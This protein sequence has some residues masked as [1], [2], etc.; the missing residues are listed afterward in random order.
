MEKFNHETATVAD[1]I[2]VMDFANGV[3]EAL[4]PNRDS[5]T[6]N[7]KDDEH[8]FYQFHA[9]AHLCQNELVERLSNYLD[10]K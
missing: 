7:Q 2:S 8:N 3:L 9:L 1:L 10:L 6:K 5:G 4:I